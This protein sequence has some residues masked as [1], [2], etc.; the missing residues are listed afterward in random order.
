MR[1]TQ[2]PQSVVPAFKDYRQREWTWL[3]TLSNDF[4]TYLATEPGEPLGSLAPADIRHRL[5]DVLYYGEVWALLRG[6]KPCVLFWFGRD[7][8]I[9]WPSPRTAGSVTSLVTVDWLADHPHYSQS[10]AQSRTWVKQV[11]LDDF[12]QRVV[13]PALGPL[14]VPYPQNEPFTA[15]GDKTPRGLTGGTNP[16]LVRLGLTQILHP[17]T[18]PEMELQFTYICYNLGGPMVPLIERALLDPQNSTVSEAI[19]QTVLDYPGSL[20]TSATQYPLVME[21]SYCVMETRLGS[22]TPKPRCL[23]SYCALQTQMTEIRD[24]F[25]R[26]RQI[27]QEIGLDVRLLL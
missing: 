4:A 11:V 15:S 13:R 20:P 3:D 17:L 19:L 10:G 22:A 24:H 25:Y 9:R 1:N 16:P 21:V 23:L 12:I 8:D 14:L 7:D 6:L 5:R 2:P 27:F 18:S 26:Y